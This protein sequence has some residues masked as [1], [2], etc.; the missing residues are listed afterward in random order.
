M[1]LSVTSYRTETTLTHEEFFW[2][3][4]TDMK[5]GEDHR[6]IDGARKK[7]VSLFVAPSNLY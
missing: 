1:C 7:L 3:K 6:E 5:R 2:A 4:Q